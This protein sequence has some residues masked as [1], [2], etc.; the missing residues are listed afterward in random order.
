M[1]ARRSMRPSAPPPIASSRCEMQACSTAPDAA[2]ASIACSRSSRPSIAR[3]KAPKSSTMPSRSR[4]RSLSARARAAWRLATSSRH[5]VT[6]R[7]F[8]RSDSAP[9][10]A[11]DDTSASSACRRAWLSRAPSSATWL[12]LACPAACPLLSPLILSSTSA[13]LRT[14]SLTCWL[15][16]WSGTA[17]G[18]GRALSRPSRRASRLS[19]DDGESGSAD[20]PAA[21]LSLI[22]CPLPCELA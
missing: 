18:E 13:S 9:R 2:R 19:S 3:R 6:S 20:E 15:V 1:W 12:R 22:F 5:A 21:G 8:R 7:T 10:A 17:P 11:T 4:P 16:R 14:T